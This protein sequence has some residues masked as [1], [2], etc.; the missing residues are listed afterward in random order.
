ML[1]VLTMAVLTV[2]GV[3]VLD[4]ITVQLAALWTPKIPLNWGFHKSVGSETYH[5]DGRY[6]TRRT[7]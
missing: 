2:V 7:R 5:C 6:W 3:A 4:L 1:T